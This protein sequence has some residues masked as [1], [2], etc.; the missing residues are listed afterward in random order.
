MLTSADRV[1]PPPRQ[2]WKA[3]QGNARSS[4]HGRSKLVS[5]HHRGPPPHGRSH[6]PTH[7]GAGPRMGA[8]HLPRASVASNTIAHTSLRPVGWQ[9]I[10]DCERRRPPRLGDETSAI[11]VERASGVHGGHQE[12]VEDGWDSFKMIQ[13]SN[14]KSTPEGE[15]SDLGPGNG[16]DSLYH[17]PTSRGSLAIRDTRPPAAPQAPVQT[18]Y[19]GSPTGETSSCPGSRARRDPPTTGDGS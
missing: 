13:I 16:V 15:S 19:K 14:K 8:D 4:V 11:T 10:L 2:E 6:H 12:R 17:Q 5:M 18:T 1:T 9:R 7:R 3:V